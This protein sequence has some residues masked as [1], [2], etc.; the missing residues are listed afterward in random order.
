M[1]GRRATALLLLALAMG[2]AGCS[3]GSNRI[4]TAS[5][6]SPGGPNVSTAAGAPASTNALP[7]VN[8]CD[9]VTSTELSAVLGAGTAHNCVPN[10]SDDHGSQH[11]AGSSQAVWG[12]PLSREATVLTSPNQLYVGLGAS[13]GLGGDAN[14]CGGP[15]SPGARLTTTDGHRTFETVYQDR[16]RRYRAPSAHHH[17]ARRPRP[18]RP[19]GTVSSIT[20][21]RPNVALYL[22]LSRPERSSQLR[23]QE[24]E[25]LKALIPVIEAALRRG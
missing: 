9:V 13:D 7:P 18:V 17:A 15:S 11:P 8:L 19:H 16:Q 4:P 2:T 23:S 5:S 3:S 20:C 21:L 22:T 25:L 14:A 12:M 10:A 1:A 24:Q 6:I